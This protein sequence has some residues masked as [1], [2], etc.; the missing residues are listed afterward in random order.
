MSADPPLV[1][2]PPIPPAPDAWYLTGATASGKTGVALELAE[3]LQAELISLDSMAL[4]RGMDIGTAKPTAAERQRV[5]HHLLDVVEPDQEFSLAEY[6][7]AAHAAIDDI[8]RRGR[9]PLFVGG[10]P[11]YLKAL[12]RGVYQGP[13]ADWEFRRQIE[14]ELQQTG[15]EALHQRARVPG[16]HEPRGASTLRRQPSGPRAWWKTRSA[17]APC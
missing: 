11:L 6:V 2:S 17:K 16:R 13:P 8:R 1:D 3:R 7:T 14:E 10:T 4:Y 15:V 9:V 5:P 12:L